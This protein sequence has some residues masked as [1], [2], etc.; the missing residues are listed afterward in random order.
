MSQRDNIIKIQSL[1]HFQFRAPAYFDMLRYAWYKSGLVQT[2]P[3]VFDTLIVFRRRFT[4]V[5]NAQDLYL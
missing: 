5:N 3:S 2:R 1:V 4:V